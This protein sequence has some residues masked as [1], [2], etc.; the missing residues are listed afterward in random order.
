MS[1]VVVVLRWLGNTSRC[2]APT[3]PSSCVHGFDCAKAFRDKVERGG[4]P[5]IVWSREWAN[6][7]SFYRSH[8]LRSDLS[9]LVRS[10]S[11]PYAPMRRYCADLSHMSLRSVFSQ[12]SA[13][14]DG[15]A[16]ACFFNT[17]W[18][19]FSWATE[20]RHQRSSATGYVDL[21]RQHNCPAN[22][23]H[24]HDAWNMDAARKHSKSSEPGKCGF[25]FHKY[26][27][28]QH[29]QSHKLETSTA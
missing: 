8:V 20:N 17:C 10:V 22:P 14:C 1:G 18:T 13:L 7:P 23:K 15:W 21:R 24:S 19:H 26:K 6:S 2:R 3:Q 27:S 4:R 25:F 29:G 9:R 11:V 12:T 16:S 28:I 5:G